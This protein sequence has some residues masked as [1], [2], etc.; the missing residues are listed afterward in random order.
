MEVSAWKSEVDERDE[1]SRTHWTSILSDERQTSEASLQR[2]GSIDVL[3]EDG[4]SSSDVSNDSGNW[5]VRGES[6]LD[7][8][9]GV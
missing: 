1:S 7:V 5:G 3:E 6:E 4:R 8:E 2:K 9:G